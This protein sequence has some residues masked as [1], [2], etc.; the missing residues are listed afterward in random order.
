MT[1]SV[2]GGQPNKPAN[3]SYKTTKNLARTFLVVNINMLEPR[4]K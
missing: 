3:T 4:L 1:M 2:V